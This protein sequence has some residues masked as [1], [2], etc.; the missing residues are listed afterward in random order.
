MALGWRVPPQLVGW[1]G[2]VSVVRVPPHCVS[3]S[4]VF[5][6]RTVRKAVGPPLI[7]CS[8]IIFFRLRH[9]CHAI[10]RVGAGCVW[11]AGALTQTHTH[12]SVHTGTPQRTS[13][14]QHSLQQRVIV[15]SSAH[16]VAHGLLRHAHAQHLVERCQLWVVGTRH[17]LLSLLLLL[18]SRPP[19]GA[20]C[21]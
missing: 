2:G 4:W 20:T 21:V 12:K 17:H 8:T 18:T 15:A 3:R 6:V 9:V 19:A 10:L 11:R 13:T 16:L 14:A 1:D 5:V 7:T